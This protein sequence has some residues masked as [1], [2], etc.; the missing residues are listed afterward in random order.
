MK[1]Y[2]NLIRWISNNGGDY[3][4]P[5][6][7]VIS[8]YLDNHEMSSYLD[9]ANGVVPRK[10]IRIRTYDNVKN[11]T[12]GY[13]NCFKEVKLTD[14][15]GKYKL[16]DSFKSQKDLDKLLYDGIY[17]RHYGLCKVNVQVNYI[18]EYFMVKESRITIDKCIIYD[19]C[20]RNHYFNNVIDPNY[21]V[22]IKSKHLEY[23]DC[24][25]SDFEF[26]RCHYSK[27]ENAVNA[28]NMV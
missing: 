6:R 18:R 4:H 26:P 19:Y 28:I 12:S 22:E 25:L 11:F 17:D 16:I 7:L 3:L 13:Q 8:R 10:K 1:L 20:E 27:Y 24:L 5:P 2:A 23:Y 14:S 9:T 21:V 15:S